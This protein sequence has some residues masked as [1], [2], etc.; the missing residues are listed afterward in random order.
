LKDLADVQT[1]IDETTRRYGLFRSTHEG[2]GVLAEEV[3]ELLLAI[4]TND[5]IDIR[6]EAIQVAAVATRIAMS[7]DNPD[8]LE[9][10]G[11]ETAE[12]ATGEA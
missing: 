6:T 1:E 12:P 7:L 11:C 5:P 10:S 4:R 2:Y 9:R 8:C 3:L